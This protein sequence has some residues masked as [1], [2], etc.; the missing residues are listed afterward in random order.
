MRLAWSSRSSAISTVV[1]TMRIPVAYPALARSR[2]PGRQPAFSC[3]DGLEATLDERSPADAQAPG[4]RVGSR[5]Q[6]P[7]HADRDHLHSR[8]LSGPAG[9]A[10]ARA[11]YLRLRRRDRRRLVDDQPLIEH[12]R[13]PPELFGL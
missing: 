4:E 7:F 6:P 5:Q 2:S 12:L 10:A 3:Q 11:P 13:R 8:A 1:F 9:F